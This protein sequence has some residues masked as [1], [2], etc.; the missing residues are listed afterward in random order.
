MALPLLTP[1]LA[2]WTGHL[3]GTPCWGHPRRNPI[4]SDGLGFRV[5]W[6]CPGREHPS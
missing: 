6:E 5:G 3:K 1:L 2:L 4:I